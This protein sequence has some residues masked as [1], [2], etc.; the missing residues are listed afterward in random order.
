[1]A[2]NLPGNATTGL[3]P[4]GSWLRLEANTPQSPKVATLPSDA[5]RWAYAATLCAAKKQVPGGCWVSERHYAECVTASV[6]R[7]LLELIGAGLV[8]IGADLCPECLGQW[9]GIDPGALVVHDWRRYQIDPTG[10]ERKQ[11]E[12]GRRDTEAAAPVTSRSRDSHGAVT[13]QSRQDG[14]RDTDEDIDLDVL[15]ERTTHGSAATSDEYLTTVVAW[16]ASHVEGAPLRSGS[17]L[18]AD[19]KALVDKHGSGVVVSQMEVALRQGSTTN[20]QLVYGADRRL[21]PIPSTR[22]ARPTGLPARQGSYDE[23]VVAR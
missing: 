23:E 22:P 9:P 7:H 15:S 8:E 21:N 19:L 12:R 3:R 13:V 14:E 10:A 17:R 2:P 1:M 20:A 4:T 6:R 16:L 18:L 11:R 5:A